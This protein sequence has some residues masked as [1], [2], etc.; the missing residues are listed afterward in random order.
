METDEPMT[1]DYKQLV[2]VRLRL[3]NLNNIYFAALNSLSFCLGYLLICIGSSLLVPSHLPYVPLPIPACLTQSSPSPHWLF[4][5]PGCH[6]QTLEGTSPVSWKPELSVLWG[7]FTPFLL[8]LPHPFCHFIFHIYSSL[9]CPSLP[10]FSS[11]SPFVILTDKP[12]TQV[13]HVD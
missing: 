11:H 13:N 7:S 3:G 8:S 9:F 5:F 12:L 6:W 4:P 2:C 1:G 10:L